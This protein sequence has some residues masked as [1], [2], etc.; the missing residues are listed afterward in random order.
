VG[1]IPYSVASDPNVPGTVNQPPE[2]DS[3]LYAIGLAQ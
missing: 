1:T 2:Q 3:T